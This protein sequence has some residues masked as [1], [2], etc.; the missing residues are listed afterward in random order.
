[1]EENKKK[2]DPH[3]L[4]KN[5]M[6][7]GG[8]LSGLSAGSIGTVKAIEK[9]YKIPQGKSAAEVIAALEKKGIS[10]KDIKKKGKLG[11]GAGVALTGLSAVKYAR[12]KKKEK[13]FTA[14]NIESGEVKLFIKE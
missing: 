1:M 14:H 12:D 9:G 7:A 4:S 8:I 13:K 5:G 3:T 6:V 10:I 11:L 2:K